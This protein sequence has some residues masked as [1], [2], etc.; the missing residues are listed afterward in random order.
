MDKVSRKEEQIN[1]AVMLLQSGKGAKKMTNADK[2]GAHHAADV[3]NWRL[4]EN[5]L[6][7]KGFQKAVIKHELSDDKLKSYVK[8]YGDYVTSRK[9][10]GSVPSRTGTHNYE[11]RKLPSGRL[12]CG[13]KDWQYK[14]SWS[15]T[16]CDHI[17]MH[18]SKSKT[19]SMNVGRLGMLASALKRRSDNVSEGKEAKQYADYL[20]Y[21][22]IKKY[23]PEEVFTSLHL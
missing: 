5:N 9:T 8:N 13:C 14:H 22:D 20:R 1:E 2:A 11:I 12:G 7:N 19:S 6:S 23:D 21:K 10:V 15:G 17:D 18:N 4:F 16:D 3:K